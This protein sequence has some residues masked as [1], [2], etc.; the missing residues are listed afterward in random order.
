MTDAPDKRFEPGAVPG[1]GTN[2]EANDVNK[3][4][5]EL[6]S[7]ILALY[8]EWYS[9]GDVSILEE[10]RILEQIWVINS[11][12]ELHSNKADA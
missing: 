3:F 6:K 10:I 9:S 1:A 2:I 4:P 8:S 5:D 7:K 11:L 12:A